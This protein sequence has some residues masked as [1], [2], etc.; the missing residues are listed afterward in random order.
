M[1][2]LLEVDDHPGRFV[3]VDGG[4]AARPA[5]DDV[6]ALFGLERVVAG[7]ADQGVEADP[8][9]D[10][11]VARAALVGVDADIAFDPVVARAAVDRPVAVVLV[12]DVVAGP[13]EI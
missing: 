6:V 10:R 8:A 3:G 9:G 4:V 5:V 13:P 1:L 7:A 12:E 2:C 11:V